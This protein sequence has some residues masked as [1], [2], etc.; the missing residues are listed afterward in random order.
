MLSYRR[1][2]RED[3]RVIAAIAAE[4]FDGGVNAFSRYYNGK[5]KPR[6]RARATTQGIGQASRRQP[7]PEYPPLD[8]RAQTSWAICRNLAFSVMYMVGCA[9][10]ISPQY[11]SFGLCILHG[12][13]RMII[14]TYSQRRETDYTF[15]FLVCVWHSAIQAG[16]INANYSNI[17]NI[18]RN[19][20]F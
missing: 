16:R 4:I 14:I 7:S 19:F 17:R 12:R 9:P 3:T 10:I 1:V 8:S 11:T 18:Y 20:R 5:T 15:R 13:C 2:A 6:F